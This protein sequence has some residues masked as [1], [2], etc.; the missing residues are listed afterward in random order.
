MFAVLNVIMAW[1]M[2]HKKGKDFFSNFVGS[3]SDA[4]VLFPLLI[5]IG[6]KTSFQLPLLFF[7]AGLLVIF[8]GI[9]YKV[10]MS[11][12]PLKSIAI[13][14]IEAKI[15]TGLFGCICSF[16]QKSALRNKQVCNQ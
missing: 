7:S 2:L 15:I 11:V 8:S 1:H 5:L 14:A 3:F 6:Q 9:Y 10:P 13:A 12:Q 4:A 16:T